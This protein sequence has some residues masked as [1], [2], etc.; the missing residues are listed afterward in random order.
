MLAVLSQVN[1][2]TYGFTYE[3]TRH[4]PVLQ[5]NRSN[6]AR[7]S[8]VWRFDLGPHEHVETT[9]IVVGKTMYLTEGVGNNVV[10]LDATTG[11]QKWRYRP[12]T[13]FMS[14]CCGAIN[15]GIA[16][17][18]RRVFEATLDAHLIALDAQTGK[19]LWTAQIGSPAQGLSETAAPLAWNGLVFIGSSGSDFGV[20]GSLSAYSAA[21]GKLLWRWYSVSR[22]W[23]GSYATGAQGMSLHRDVARE[24]KDAAKYGH[25]WQR[26]GGAVWMTPALDTRSG[27]LFFTTSNPYPVFSA[28]QRPGDNLYTECIVALD[29]RTGKMRWYYQQTPHDV[30]EY[31]SSSP[32]VLFD[33]ADAHGRSTPAVGEAGK[34][35]WFYVLRRDNGKPLRITAYAPNHGLYDAPA[36]DR[37]LLPFR[38]NLDPVS[39]DAQRHLAFVTAIDQRNAETPRAAWRDFIA[40]VDVNTGRIAWT[41]T[42]NDWRPGTFGDHMVPGSVSTDRLLFVPEPEG[43]LFALDSADGTVLWHR[44]LGDGA[45]F[46]RSAGVLQRVAHRI[47]DW[48]EPVKRALLH[49]DPAPNAAASVSGNPIIYQVAGR[50]Y[51]AVGFDAAPDSAAGGAEIYAFALPNE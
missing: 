40:A 50:A 18:G 31:E 15:R 46:D 6:V 17:D 30:W 33:A 13:G 42:L 43:G 29:A 38:G 39:Y 16:T 45:D 1:W 47:H 32:P 3:N 8:P 35:R 9:P 24:K 11:K 51:V 28:A 4:V 25:A 23:E 48:L 5:I 44:Q 7:L 27:T 37:D 36:S 21:N 26:G 41:R 2:S 49:Q 10:A 14:A 22:G 19:H 20:R 12:S 34:N